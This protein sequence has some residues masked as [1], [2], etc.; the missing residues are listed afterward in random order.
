VSLDP[1]L[2]VSIFDILSNES[3][4]DYSVQKIYIYIY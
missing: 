2:I 4:G 1:L 3:G